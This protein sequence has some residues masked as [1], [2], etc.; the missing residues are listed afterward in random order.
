[1]TINTLIPD[2]VHTPFYPP[3]AFKPIVSDITE[4]LLFLISPI[5]Y[6]PKTVLLNLEYLKQKTVDAAATYKS[7]A[8]RPN[9]S[10]LV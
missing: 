4:A 10:L 2:S 3:E 1:M 6:E 8:P 7:S 5:S 9:K